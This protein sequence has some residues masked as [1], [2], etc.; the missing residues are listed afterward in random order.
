M[1]SKLTQPEVISDLVLQRLSRLVSAGSAPVTRLCEG[2]FG[3]TKREWRILASL[4][5]NECL[6]SSE[7]ATHTELDRAR[8][9]RAISSLLT[10]GLVAR[11]IMTHDQRKATITMTDKGQKLYADFF[12]IVA[13]LNQRLLNGLSNTELLT[14]DKALTHLQKNAIQMQ[15]EHGQP[16]ANRRRS[17][18][19]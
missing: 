11:Q 4:A 10:K 2:K 5:P 13:E 14:L 1:N 15:T 9:S 3:I 18:K 17:G 8:T 19:K 12:P 16:K 6:L 7:L